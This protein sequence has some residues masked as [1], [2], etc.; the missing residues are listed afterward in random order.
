MFRGGQQPILLIGMR[1][2]HDSA[3]FLLYRIQQGF[4]ADRLF[5]AA[6]RRRFSA[7]EALALRQTQFNQDHVDALHVAHFS[8]RVEQ[9]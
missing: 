9:A 4:Q 1:S 7:L 6:Q 2:S 3:M 8:G 5:T